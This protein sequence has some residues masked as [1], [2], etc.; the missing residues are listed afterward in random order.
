MDRGFLNGVITHYDIH[1]YYD[2]EN[3]EDV[4]SITELRSNLIATFP[5]LKVFNLVPKKVINQSSLHLTFAFDLNF[6]LARIL[7]RCSNLIWSTK[8]RYQNLIVSSYLNIPFI[9]Q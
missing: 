3:K 2:A 7:W 5:Q 1:I 4:D 6:R 8:K 9:L